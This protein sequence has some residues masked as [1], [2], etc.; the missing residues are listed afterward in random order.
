MECTVEWGRC[1]ASIQLAV[2]RGLVAL[3]VVHLAVHDV[4][5]RLQARAL[6]ARRAGAP[7]LRVP[8]AVLLAV[9][10][11]R[12]GQRQPQPLACTQRVE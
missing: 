9:L 7:L 10:V 12:R 11:E 8:V 2:L 6:G 3:H 5:E 1:E 4:L